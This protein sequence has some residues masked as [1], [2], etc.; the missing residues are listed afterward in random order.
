MISAQTL[1]WSITLG[2]LPAI[3]WLLFWLREDKKNPEPPHVIL[4]CFLLGGI[5]VI[6]SITLEKFSLPYVSRHPMIMLITWSLI[7]EGLKLVAALFGGLRKRWYNEPID[8]VIYLL[9]VALGFAAF[10]NTLYLF[11][12]FSNSNF[13]EGLVISNFRFIGASLLHFVSSAILGSFIAFAFYKN[14]IHRSIYV[15]IGLS[16]ATALHAVFNLLIIEDALRHTILAFVVVWISIVVCIGLFERIKRISPLS[17]QMGSRP[18][19]V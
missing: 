14:K 6:G 9:A 3:L 15:F 2:A 5:A 19:N 1:L 10:E 11:E 4:A 12:P 7:E 17:K 8:A 16:T 13:L 18:L